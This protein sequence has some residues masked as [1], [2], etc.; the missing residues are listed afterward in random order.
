MFSPL[1]V[2]FTI[3]NASEKQNSRKQKIIYWQQILNGYGA[4]CQLQDLILLTQ[5]M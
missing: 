1:Y 3:M 4:V 2:Q 5:Y